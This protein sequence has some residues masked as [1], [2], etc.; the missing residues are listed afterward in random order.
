MARAWED[1]PLRSNSLPKWPFGNRDPGSPSDQRETCGLS[2]SA[3]GPH[4]QRRPPGGPR[5]A[6]PDRR[7]APTRP[8]WSRTRPHRGHSAI[9]GQELRTGEPRPVLGTES[10]RLSRS[11]QMVRRAR[12]PAHDGLLRAGSSASGSAGAEEGHGAEWLDRAGMNSPSTTSTTKRPGWLRLG[13]GG[14]SVAPPSPGDSGPSVPWLGQGHGDDHVRS[15]KF[16]EL[17]WPGSLRPPASRGSHPDGVGPGSAR[18]PPGTGT[19]SGH[20]NVWKPSTHVA[21][22]ARGPVGPLVLASSW[23]SPRLSVLGGQV[24]VA[25]ALRSERRAKGRSSLMRRW[26]RCASPGSWSHGRLPWPECEVMGCR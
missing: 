26:R 9:P 22:V 10:H 1:P 13:L 8:L 18:N 5:Q 6:G 17:L 23:P 11:G 19:V 4:S 16:P 21:E 12:G 24:C 25:P 3:H 2:H 15:A 20:L 14:E 7:Q